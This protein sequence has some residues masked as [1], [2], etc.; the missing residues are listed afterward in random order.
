[1][2]LSEKQHQVRDGDGHNE[3]DERSV[4]RQQHGCHPRGERRHLG[5]GTMGRGLRVHLPPAPP[6]RRDGER[7]RDHHDDGGCKRV[8]NDA[9]EEHVFY[10]SRVALPVC[11]VRDAGSVDYCRIEPRPE[12]V[13]AAA[14]E[15]RD[16]SA[17]VGD[18]FRADS[19]HSQRQTHGDKTFDAHEDD[20]P[21]AQHLRRPIRP[22][23]RPTS[24]LA[25]GAY[26][27]PNHIAKK[28]LADG[29]H[30]DDH[31]VRQGES[32]QE[33]TDARG[34]EML[35]QHHADGEHVAANARYDYS[36]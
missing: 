29:R 17:D 8:R 32:G 12:G 28:T 31:G 9:E 26:I 5:G 35:S 24:G 1:V 15:Q 20:D 3:N 34:P 11:R 16:D 4:R 6:E 10:D 33:H 23:E 21:R 30:D 13:E 22:E 14:D 25:E 19:L 18:A 27:D 7:V 2:L 36:G